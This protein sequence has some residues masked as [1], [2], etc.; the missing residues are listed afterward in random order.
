[1]DEFDGYVLRVRGI[2]AA[3][4]SE[5]PAAAKKALGHFAAS[6]SQTQRFRGEKRFDELIARQQ[7]LANLLREFEIRGHVA[8]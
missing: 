2:R 7:A 6:L 8:S 4:K 3:A 5:Q 1:M